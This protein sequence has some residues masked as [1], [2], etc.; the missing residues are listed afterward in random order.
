MGNIWLLAAVG[1]V[2]GFLLSGILLTFFG[3]VVLTVTIISLNV[4]LFTRQR[5]ADTSGACAEFLFVLSLSAGLVIGMLLVSI[6]KMI[7]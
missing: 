3:T 5:I 6:Y 4:W 2:A 1:A 7:A